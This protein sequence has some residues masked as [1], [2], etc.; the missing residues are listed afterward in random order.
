MKNKLRPDAGLPQ[1]VEVTYANGTIDVFDEII[2]FSA[3]YLGS[4]RKEC[5][6]D[7]RITMATL[8]GKGRNLLDWLVA[9]ILSVID[10]WRIPEE[11]RK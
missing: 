8:E 3:K 4:D 9:C 2:D 7:V 10:S 6:V 5:T 1:R 11:W